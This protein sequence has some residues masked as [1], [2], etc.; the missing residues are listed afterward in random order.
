MMQEAKAETEY[1]STVGEMNPLRVLEPFGEQ[2]AVLCV[3]SI[4]TRQTAVGHLEEKGEWLRSFW[5]AALLALPDVGGCRLLWNSLFFVLPNFSVTQSI[6]R[7][8]QLLYSHQDSFLESLCV[9]CKAEGK[10]EHKLDVLDVLQH[11]V[12]GDFGASLSYQPN[13]Y[14]FYHLRDG[15]PYS[16]K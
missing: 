16:I 1:L 8:G 9:L 5:E 10:P 2:H 12:G 14:R 3:V 13:G 7:L 15:R 11:E 6:E 4:W